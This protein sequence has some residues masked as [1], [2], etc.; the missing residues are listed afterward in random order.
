MIGKVICWGRDRDEAI[1]RTLR[2]LDE[3]AV[4]GIVTTV[5]LHQ[6]IVDGSRFRSGDFNTSFVGE[7]LARRDASA[8]AASA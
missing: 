3:L 2:A 4:E 7:P 6:G 1:A 8:S 5:T